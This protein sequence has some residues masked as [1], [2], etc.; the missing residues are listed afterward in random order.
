[1]L[2]H[3]CL[4][5]ILLFGIFVL[6][7]S[8]AVNSEE[9]TAQNAAQINNQTCPMRVKGHLINLMDEHLNDVSTWFYLK[10]SHLFFKNYVITF[11]K[12]RK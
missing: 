11:R 5:F 1:M 12:D 6:V 10:M 2:V 7:A 9:T 8:N 4:D 3:T